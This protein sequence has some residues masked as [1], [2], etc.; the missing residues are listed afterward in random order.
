MWD[1][2]VCMDGG[3]GTE[4]E[5]LGAQQVRCLYL[6]IQ[7]IKILNFCLPVNKVLTNKLGKLRIQNRIKLVINFNLNGS[8]KQV[9]S[10]RL[11]SA[12][13]NVNQPEIVIQAHT[14]FIKAG[15]RLIVANSYQAV[16]SLFI[17]V[18]VFD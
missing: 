3:M 11:W 10:H 1:E 12:I 14:N 5:A 18:L 9:N 17:E 6:L 15:S 2:I 8:L 16:P 4:L 7:L 13:A